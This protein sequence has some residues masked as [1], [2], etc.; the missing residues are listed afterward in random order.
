[1]DFLR[2]KEKAHWITEGDAN[3]SYFH[4]VIRARRN[5][6][7]IQHIKDHR[8]QLFT[9][10][11]GIQNDLLLFCKGDVQSMML[12]LRTFSTFSISSGLRMSKGK[13]N[14]Y[15]NGVRDNIK[16]E[17]LQVSGMMEGALP[18]RSLG[19]KKLSYAGRLVLVKAVLK[20]FHIYW[21]SMFIFPTGIIHNIE[22]ICR[23]FLWDGGTNYI[24]TPLVSWDKIC[25]A[26]EEGGLGLKD[27]ILWN[28]A[29]VDKLV[30]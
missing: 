7:F 28:K 13:S 25:K 11:E 30:W 14:A 18:F 5:K 20:T 21:A 29:A 22:A 1:M 3:F 10:E 24:K 4:G 26:K 15:F 9:D 19:A 8:D 16:H 17:I 12:I 6:N 23:N 27:D 2:Q